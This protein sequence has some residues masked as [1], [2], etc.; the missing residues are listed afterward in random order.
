MRMSTKMRTGIPGVTVQRAMNE[1]GEQLREDV[2]Q[3]GVYIG[4]VVYV[5]RRHRGGGSTYG[6]R[7]AKATRSKLTNKVEAI[8]RLPKFAD[9]E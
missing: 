7:P 1:D 6:W 9:S 8:R 3:D 2:E 4:Q 5:R